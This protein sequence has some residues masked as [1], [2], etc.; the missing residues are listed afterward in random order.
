MS[1]NENGHGI[2]VRMSGTRSPAP[3]A[4]ARGG[5]CADRLIGRRSTGYLVKR[6]RRRRRD[7][8][9]RAATTAPPPKPAAARHHR[10]RRR[11]PTAAAAAAPSHGGAPA[12]I[13]LQCAAVQNG[14]RSSYRARSAHW[15]VLEADEAEA[16]HLP[17]SRSRHD[18]RFGD[19]PVR[20]EGRPQ[21]VVIRFPLTRPPTK[22]FLLIRFTFSLVTS[23]APRDRPRVGFPAR[24][25]VTESL[26]WGYP[27]VAYILCVRCKAG[28]QGRFGVLTCPSPSGF[29]A[30]SSSVAS[31]RG[32][33]FMT[34]SF[35]LVDALVMIWGRGNE[36]WK[37]AGSPWGA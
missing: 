3:A 22:S 5:A 10:R 7:H 23:R 31:R 21:G 8:R 29:A 20:L 32:G 18:L 35:V 2:R 11:A 4:V 26:T 36:R 17:V 28:I 33:N 13:D 24:P 37:A 6:S 16:R 12:R 27:S 30:L 9:R 14:L 19:R 34:K 25:G 15:L 1:R